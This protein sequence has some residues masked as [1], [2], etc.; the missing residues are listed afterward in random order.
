MDQDSFYLSVAAD[1][2]RN[3]VG[4]TV[5]LPSPIKAE[6][7]E[8]SLCYC[9]FLPKW[10]QFQEL[11]FVHTN[12]KGVADEMVFENLDYMESRELLG[13][14][15]TAMANRY[16]IN[17]KTARL[18]IEIHKD[19]ST[20]LKIQRNSKV[21]FSD[22]LAYIL[23]VDKE[24]VNENETKTRML[25]LRPQNVGISLHSGLYL[26]SCEEIAAQ[27]VTS[28]GGVLRVLDFMQ[29]PPFQNNIPFQHFPGHKAYHRLEGSLLSSL[30]C[31][32]LNCYGN[33]IFTE[34][35]QFY[36]I[37]HF[38]KIRNDT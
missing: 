19:G 37:L 34:D 22:M 35:P 6:N 1:S 36:A 28:N 2:A 32:I 38:R 5:F 16:G 3:T 9:T 30:T 18:K 12:E 25:P 4:G 33:P 20:H 15:S 7:Y 29:V 26:L 10:I 31:R 27:Y 24:I 11:S 23:G 13:Y 8:I 17:M 21:V 14:L